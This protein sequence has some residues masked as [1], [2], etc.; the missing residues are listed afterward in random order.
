MWRGATLAKGF[1]DGRTMIVGGGFN[2][3]LVLYPIAPGKGSK[4]L[5]NWVVTYRMGDGSNPPPRREDWNR[6]GTLRELMPHVQRF[7]TPHVD[8]TKLVKGAPAFYEYPMADRDPVQRWTHGR[9]TLLGDAAHPMYPVG[10]NGASQAILDA[11]CLADLLVASEHARAALAAY[12]ADRLPKTAEIV[13]NNRKGGPEGVIDEVERLA[14]DGFD[15]VDD[16]LSHA[17]REAI[18][19]GYAQ[20]AGFAK[21]QVNRGGGTRPVRATGGKRDGNR[22]SRKRRG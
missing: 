9:V 12:E 13:R 1:L 3:K 16:V 19:K 20:L 5:I 2:N 10:S 6:K 18:V 17:Q 22:S 8:L 15:D 7:S 4:Q 21:E 11:R 14:P